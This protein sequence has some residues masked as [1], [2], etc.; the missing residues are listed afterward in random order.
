[1]ARPGPK[2][3]QEKIRAQGQGRQGR[4]LMQGPRA[5]QCKGLKQWKSLIQEPKTKQ[6]K[7]S[8][9]YKARVRCNA[10]EPEARTGKGPRLSKAR[11]RGKARARSMQG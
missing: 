5:S 9:Q 7:F 11:A 2:A 10:T 6:G 4:G 1:M 3:K 8:M